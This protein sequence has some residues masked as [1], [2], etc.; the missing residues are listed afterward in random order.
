[1]LLLKN[2]LLS[3]INH[4]LPCM[5]KRLQSKPLQLVFCYNHHVPSHPSPP[6]S[7]NHLWDL[8]QGDPTVEERSGNGRSSTTAPDPKAASPLQAH[9]VD[10]TSL[11]LATTNASFLA[12]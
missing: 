6:L 12:A 1:M 8:Q 7:F 4:H 5:A 9:S 10:G 2:R 11:S 3:P